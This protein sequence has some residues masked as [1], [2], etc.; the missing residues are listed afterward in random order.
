M[1]N[2]RFSFF[3][4]AIPVL[5]NGDQEVIAS[6]ILNIS[7][8]GL[9]Y[10]AAGGELTNA[11]AGIATV[12]DYV[13]NVL[14]VLPN[15][16]RY[17]GA[18]RIENKIINSEDLTVM[19]TAF[20][21]TINSAVNVTFGSVSNSRIEYDSVSNIIDTDKATIQCRIRAATPASVGKTVLFAL[22]DKDTPFAT[23][24]IY[25][26]LTDTYVNISAEEVGVT[27][28]QTGAKVIFR[29]DEV[30]EVVID[31]TDIQ[32]ENVT[33]QANKQAGEYVSTEIV[34]NSGILNVAYLD[35]APSGHIF[36][37]EPML[38]HE[39]AGI[40]YALNSSI[41]AT[42]TISLPA[43]DYTVW[44]DDTDTLGSITLSGGATGSVSSLDSNGL[45]FT[46]SGSDVTF[47]FTGSGNVRWQVEERD[48]R[49]SYIETAG[50]S[51]SRLSDVITIPLSVGD[52]LIQ[53]QGMMLFRVSSEAG[54][55][56]T[57]PSEGLI[58]FGDSNTSI[59][60]DHGNTGIASYDGTNIN[61]INKNDLTSP[62]KEYIF[63]VI[64]NDAEGSF[65]LVHTNDVGITWE[66]WHDNPYD[67]TFS[68]GAL[69]T[70]FRQNANRLKLISAQI[71][72]ELSGGSISS[73][74]AW[75]EMNAERF[76]VP[77]FGTG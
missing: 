47:T 26:V 39:G 27:A 11:K 69:I 46:G 35:T 31:V 58:N 72:G 13:G 60:Y 55:P 6:R 23:D 71:Y 25:H 29:C 65:S 18:R 77:A 42:Q 57:P 34:H 66:A 41:P 14:E 8:I 54:Y 10:D 22:K 17:L 37:T 50:V 43:A 75:V 62:T 44:F 19:W 51:A 30:T 3:N 33:L 74:K 24:G 52:N 20:T 28:G 59:L 53:E 68:T 40:N 76:T 56:N 49:T 45:Q 48:F 7:N 4:N 5:S 9:N 38:L 15:E 32:V 61:L 70:L 73:A 67:G 16:I 64:W 63:A 12:V 1:K 21:A 36:S 2:F